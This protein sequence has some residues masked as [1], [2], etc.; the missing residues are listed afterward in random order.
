MAEAFRSQA[1][2]CRAL[3]SSFTARLLALCAQGLDCD[4]PVGARI[5]AWPGD[6][7]SRGAS[8]PLRLAG[9]LNLLRL[10]GDAHLA[11][12]WPPHDADDTALWD[13]V[14]GVLRDR[15]AEVLAGL[16]SPPQTNEVR[17]SAALILAAHWLAER[18]DLPLVLSELGASA[19]L[20]LMFDHFALATPDGPRGAVAAALQLTP[21]WRGGP[22]PAYAPFQVVERRGVDLSPVDPGDPAGRRRL[23]SYIWPDQ[24]HRIALTAAALTVAK[25]PLDRGDAVDWLA[26]R[27]TPRPGCLHL[28]FHTIAWQYFP[29]ERQ[30]RGTA[31]LAE[32]GRAATPDAPIAHLAVEAD[33]RD[34]GA[35]MVLR[36]WDGH[37]HEGHTVSLGR[38]DYH[39]RWIDWQAPRPRPKQDKE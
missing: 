14:N 36:L 31:L 35:G 32:A 1:E 6:I 33:G 28:V 25:A 11:A 26:R 18:I 9:T 38:M 39:G 29:T 24:P 19:G 13:A 2:S 10:S 12:V 16:D 22:P 37:M 4:T 7:G 3:G 20:N 27:L 23:M 21:E 15:S 17:R 30:A 8:V 34:P 5:A